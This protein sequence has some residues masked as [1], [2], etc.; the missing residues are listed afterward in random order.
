MKKDS[1]IKDI[2]KA[3]LEIRTLNQKPDLLLQDQ[4]KVFS[5]LGK[6]NRNF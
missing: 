2:L 6:T 1:D 5:K 4:I 3:E